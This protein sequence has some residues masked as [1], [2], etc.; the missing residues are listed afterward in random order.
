MGH[1]KDLGKRVV[2]RDGD[3]DLNTKIR[4]KG[5]VEDKVVDKATT[6][7]KLVDTSFALFNMVVVTAVTNMYS[8]NKADVI[9]KEQND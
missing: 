4:G 3:K 6:T 5:Q 9:D 1:S 8:I 2:A 7:H